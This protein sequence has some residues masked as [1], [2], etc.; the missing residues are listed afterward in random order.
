MAGVKCNHCDG[1]G[2]VDFMESDSRVVEY[3]DCAQ[4]GGI[5]RLH[6][7]DCAYWK[8]MHGPHDCTCGIPVREDEI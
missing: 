5:G 4:C 3:R 7:P 1:K 2:V 6:D 8:P